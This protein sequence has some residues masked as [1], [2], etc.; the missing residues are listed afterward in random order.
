MS[1][2]SPYPR[3]PRPY[4]KGHSREQ[5]ERLANELF[6]GVTATNKETGR[7][8]HHYLLADGP[9]ERRGFEALRRLLSFSC[10]DLDSGILAA[11]YCS[12]DSDGG[13]E[14]QLVF[15]FRKKGNRHDF[16]ADLQIVLHIE[17]LVRV[18]QKKEAAI[19][20]TMSDLGL[21]RKTVFAAA[22]RVKARNL[23]KQTLAVSLNR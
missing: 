20:Q 4:Y 9:H 14:R 13:N 2:D 17:G 6:Y 11:L 5:D 7:V 22:K 12:L 16:T 8:R 1:H 18:G 10:G 3:T 23:L 19:R 15:K 21:S